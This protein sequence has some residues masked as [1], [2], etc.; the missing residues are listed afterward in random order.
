M[1]YNHKQ[2]KDIHT[3]IFD[4]HMELKDQILQNELMMD[5]KD[6][7]IKEE[8]KNKIELRYKDSCNFVSS[9]SKENKERFDPLEKFIL[10]FFAGAKNDIHKLYENYDK[11]NEN[12][13]SFD[14]LINYLDNK[15]DHVIDILEKY[16]KD[17]I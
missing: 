3:S 8:L 4:N 7:K 9:I 11:L 6:Y 14:Q 15:I 1:K 13:E 17:V 5:E 12:H 2:L 16:K 10:D